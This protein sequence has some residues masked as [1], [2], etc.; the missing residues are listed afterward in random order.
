MNAY[1]LCITL[2][3][4]ASTGCLCAITPDC[5]NHKQSGHDSFVCVCTESQPCDRIVGAVKTEPNVVTRWESSRDGAR[6]RKQS[7][8]FN[9]QVNSEGNP[10]AAQLH[11]KVNRDLKH[12]EIFGFGGAF[13]DSTGININKLGDKLGAQVLD[14]YFSKEGI[15][16]NVGRIPIGGSDFS[17][18]PYALDDS[19]DDLTLKKWNL[20]A[21]DLQYKI[22]TILKAKALATHEIRLFG[23]PWSAPKWMKTNNDLVHGGSIK[24]EVGS[25]YWQTWAN[26]FVHYLNA[27]KAHNITHWGITIQNEPRANQKFN[28]MLY[29]PEQMR[30]FLV[31]TLGPELERSGWGPDKLKVMILDHNLDLIKEWVRVIFADAGARKYAAGTATHWYSSSPHTYLDEPHAQHP[32]KFILATEACMGPH[33]RLGLWQLAERYAYDILGSLLHHTV[34]W[35]DWN[36]VLDT[37]GGPTWVSNFV[38]APIIANPAGHE[39]YRQPSF[40]AMAHFSKFLPPGSVRVDSPTVTQQG[41]KATAGA[42]RTPHGS[43]VVV[44]VNNDETDIE[45]TLEDTTAG[46]LSAKIDRK[47]IHTYVYYD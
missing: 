1:I 4:I 9:K 32:D 35:T 37:Q 29:T 13:T 34:G 19:G 22:P 36:M 39:Y 45:F 10:L 2:T 7:L 6:L 33:V 42:F 21:E 11:I 12:Q 46:K 5:K 18:R 25:Q 16:Y 17:P 8:H 14:D 23:S 31:K 27:Y 44:V 38:D 40:Y 26:Y 47:S 28:S 15:E 3:V 41:N 24:G 30:D 43:T 20:T